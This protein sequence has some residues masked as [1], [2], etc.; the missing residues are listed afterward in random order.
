M[1]NKSR[2]QKRDMPLG[3]TNL[4]NK[5]TKVKKKKANRKVSPVEIASNNM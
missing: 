3:V 5:F 4:K 1:K 2:P